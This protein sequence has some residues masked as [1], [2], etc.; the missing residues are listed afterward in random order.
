[1]SAHKEFLLKTGFERVVLN[2][3]ICFARLQSDILVQAQ[4]N[5]M[6][7]KIASHAKLTHAVGLL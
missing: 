6:N 1:M 7:S 3:G 5:G 4:S 2:H